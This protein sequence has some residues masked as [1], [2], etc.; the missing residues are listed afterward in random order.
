[1]DILIQVFVVFGVLAYLGIGVVI[2]Y[3]VAKWTFDGLTWW[4]VILVALFWPL[5]VFLPIFAFISWVR[6]GSH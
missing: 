5:A 1:M 4:Q 6:S 3:G 2:A